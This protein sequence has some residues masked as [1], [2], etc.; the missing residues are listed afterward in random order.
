M[1]HS[2]RAQQGQAISSSLTP[3]L[4]ILLAGNDLFRVDRRTSKLSLRIDS[5]ATACAPFWTLALSFDVEE[6]LQLLYKPGLVNVCNP[7]PGKHVLCPGGN[8]LWCCGW[9]FSAILPLASGV[10]GCSRTEL[11]KSSLVRRAMK[12]QPAKTVAVRTIVIVQ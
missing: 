5:Q 12:Y 2:G 10:G 11:W 7:W 3:F 8:D 4:T 1:Y 9:I 6:A